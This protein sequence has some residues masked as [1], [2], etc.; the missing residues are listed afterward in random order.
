MASKPQ[1][2][3]VREWLMAQTDLSA[4]FLELDLDGNGFV[5]K[6]E[7]AQYARGLPPSIPRQSGRGEESHD[8]W[9]ERAAGHAFKYIG[10][11]SEDSIYCSE[12]RADGCFGCPGCRAYH[13][14]LR[15]SAGQAAATADRQKRE[16]C[17]ALLAMA[18]TDGDG[19]VSLTEFLQLGQVLQDVVR[20]A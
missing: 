16:L 11:N 9:A 10:T 20:R 8:E 6:R 14:W 17:A 18:D 7:L 2:A 5:T 19:K 4:T 15:S 12:P 3:L 13:E 1:R